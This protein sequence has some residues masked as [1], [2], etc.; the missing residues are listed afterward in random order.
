MRRG[1]ASHA[2]CGRRDDLGSWISSNKIYCFDSICS[3]S[4]IDCFHLVVVA[5][6]AAT[7][8][9]AFIGADTI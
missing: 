4:Q 5:I 8:F 1:V 6:G 9:F 3:L 7:V 2:R